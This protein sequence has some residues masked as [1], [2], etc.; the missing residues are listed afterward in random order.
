MVMLSRSISRYTLT[1]VNLLCSHRP[2]H[3]LEDKD[4][5][6]ARYSSP[7]GSNFRISQVLLEPTLTADNYRARMHD[8]LYV[9]EIAQ[10]AKISRF[11]P[12]IFV[13]N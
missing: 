3:M 10:Y 7:V 6:L 2:S 5:L 4:Q 1:S 12:A 8:L 9:E 13:V 11:G